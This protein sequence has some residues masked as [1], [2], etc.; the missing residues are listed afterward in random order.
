[1]HFP[2]NLPCGLANFDIAHWRSSLESMADQRIVVP[3]SIAHNK[4]D[5]HTLWADAST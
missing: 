2:F 1:M 5:S 3:L 4:G